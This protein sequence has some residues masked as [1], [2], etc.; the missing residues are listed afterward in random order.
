MK[1]ITFTKKDFSKSADGVFK[2]SFTVKALLRAV[3]A[4]GRNP[5]RGR[6]TGAAQADID[7]RINALK[8]AVDMRGSVLVPTPEHLASR[9]TDKGLKS[10]Y[11]GNALCA[12]AADSELN[13]PWL[14]DFER[15]G[16]NYS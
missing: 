13:I 4:A 6:K 10:F 5:M 7:M 3:V 2:L 11:V 9:S 16:T 12:H 14:V 15:L 8:S 1:Q